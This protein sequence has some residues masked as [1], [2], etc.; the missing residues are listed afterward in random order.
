[1]KF[2]EQIKRLA[3]EIYS[4]VVSFIHDEGENNKIF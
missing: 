4:K 1:M 2:E 3:N